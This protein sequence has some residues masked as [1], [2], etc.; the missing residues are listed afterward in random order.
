MG[1]GVK[2]G[3]G[4]GSKG[5]GGWTTQEAQKVMSFVCRD[6]S[7]D[8]I[9][10]IFRTCQPPIKFRDFVSKRGKGEGVKSMTVLTLLTVTGAVKWRH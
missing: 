3:E 6:S 7:S 5:R 2:C 9:V 10:Q 1:F 8:A 4:R